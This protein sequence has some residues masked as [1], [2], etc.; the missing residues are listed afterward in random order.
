MIKSERGSV[1]IN[2]Y[3]VECLVEYQ[4]LTKRLILAAPENV[5]P[6]VAAEIVNAVKKAVE[7]TMKGGEKNEKS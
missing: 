1:E 3:M 5:R 7:E 2:G 6:H 4:M